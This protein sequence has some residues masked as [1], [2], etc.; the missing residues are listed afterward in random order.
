MRRLLIPLSALCCILAATGSLAQNPDNAETLKAQP[1]AAEG[2]WIEPESNSD[3][4]S[5]NTQEE[6]PEPP[7][8]ETT[9]IED[10]SNS[11]EP[12]L[13]FSRPEFDTDRP[14]LDYRNFDLRRG[15]HYRNCMVACRRDSRCRA[16]TF[17]KAGVQGPSAR[18]WLK[19]AW[20]GKVAASCC[21]SGI[22]R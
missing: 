11:S 13:A 4:P 3:T 7:S 18:C 15:G 22:I 9:N 16:W 5:D 8:D 20:P 19:T 1:P 6:E 2:E 14:G 10:P 21:I 17:V 12:A